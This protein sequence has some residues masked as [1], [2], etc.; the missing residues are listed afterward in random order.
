[1]GSGKSMMFL[2]FSEQVLQS[3]ALALRACTALTSIRYPHCVTGTRRSELSV[4]LF[5]DFWSF[6]LALPSRFGLQLLVADWDEWG[7]ASAQKVVQEKAVA[8]TQIRR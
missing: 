6:R 5:L 4:T 8:I 3:R 2:C 7:D 1:M